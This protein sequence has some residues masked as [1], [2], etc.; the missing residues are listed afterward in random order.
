MGLSLPAWATLDFY[1]DGVLLCCVLLQ[2]SSTIPCNA[3]VGTGTPAGTHVYVSEYSGDG[4]YG[5][6]DLE[7]GSDHHESRHSNGD[8]EQFAPHRAFRAGGDADRERSSGPTRRL[9]TT[10]RHRPVIRSADRHS[11]LHERKHDDLCSGAAGTLT[12][13]ASSARPHAPPRRCQW[14]RTPSR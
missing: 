12:S 13:R 4:T 1:Q 14:G 2:A 10:V 5:P 11:H 7:S 6:I 9:G 8:D 3:N